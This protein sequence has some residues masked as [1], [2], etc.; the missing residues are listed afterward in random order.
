MVFESAWA[1]VD[2]EVLSACLVL[3]FRR[4]KSYLQS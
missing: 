4:R 2:G 3:K 1:L